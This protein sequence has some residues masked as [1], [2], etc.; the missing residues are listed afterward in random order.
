MVTSASDRAEALPDGRTDLG[1][2]VAGACRGL[3]SCPGRAT[4]G[5]AEAL[6]CRAAAAFAASHYGKLHVDR[7]LLLKAFA[8][9][10]LGNAVINLLKRSGSTYDHVRPQREAHCTGLSAGLANAHTRRRWRRWPPRP[11]WQCTC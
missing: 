6:P 3:R 1:N 9:L 2:L 7:T 10:A 11:C 5:G 8:V 4:G